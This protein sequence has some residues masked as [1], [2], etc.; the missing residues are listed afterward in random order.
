MGRIQHVLEDVDLDQK[1]GHRV[2]QRDLIHGDHCI[3]YQL[4]CFGISYHL[5]LLVLVVVPVSRHLDE[6]VQEVFAGIYAAEVV[7][8]PDVMLS[9]TWACGWVGFIMY[10]KL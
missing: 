6:A 2:M 5:Q 9:A 4:V 7:F 10:W 1:R 3:Q 8:A